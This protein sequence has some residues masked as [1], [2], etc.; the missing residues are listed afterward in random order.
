MEQTILSAQSAGISSI[1]IVIPLKDN[2]CIPIERKST[3]LEARVVSLLCD[4]TEML[5]HEN[6]RS[7]LFYHFVRNLRLHSYSNSSVNNI[8]FL[9]SIQYSTLLELWFL[10]NLHISLVISVCVHLTIYLGFTG[11]LEGYVHICVSEMER[12]WPKW[13]QIWTFRCYSW[14]ER[15]TW[16]G[17]CCCL[18]YKFYMPIF[19]DRTLR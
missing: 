6:F 2:M 8:Y 17:C 3:Q 11:L 13:R 10:Y 12:P 16:I 5:S 18:L 4:S 14:P 1:C 7:C 15:H 9:L 19:K